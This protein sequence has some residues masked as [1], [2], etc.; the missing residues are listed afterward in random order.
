MKLMEFRSVT[1]DQITDILSLKA[2]GPHTQV[3]LCP[4]IHHTAASFRTWIS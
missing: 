4:L 3:I 1:L 2:P